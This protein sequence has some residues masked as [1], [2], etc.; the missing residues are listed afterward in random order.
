MLAAANAAVSIR[1]ELDDRPEAPVAVL[2][3][4][5]VI[6][7]ALCEATIG[8]GHALEVCE[9]EHVQVLWRHPIAGLPYTIIDVVT[10]AHLPLFVER[11][12]LTI[13]NLMAHHAEAASEAVKKFK[14]ERLG[15][16]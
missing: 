7:G 6:D 3:P 12:R 5:I 1:D 10:E 14:R 8:A 4:V 13:H 11:F 2:L 16:A 9:V 15:I